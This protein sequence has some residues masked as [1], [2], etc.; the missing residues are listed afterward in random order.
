MH[1]NHFLNMCEKTLNDSYFQIGRSNKLIN[2]KHLNKKLIGL[3][4]EENSAIVSYSFQNK[5]SF[6]ILC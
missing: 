3:F 6:I 1:F 5:N 2:Y 4:C